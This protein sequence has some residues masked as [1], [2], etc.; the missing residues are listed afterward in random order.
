MGEREQNL[1]REEKTDGMPDVMMEIPADEFSADEFS[2]MRLRLTGFLQMKFRQKIFR[3]MRFRSTCFRM[4]R[5]R[6]L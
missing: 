4:N 1:N 6:S 2:Q 5:K 3:L